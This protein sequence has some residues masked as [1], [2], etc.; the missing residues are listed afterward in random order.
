MSEPKNRKF[1]FDK[2]NKVE[3]GLYAR[4]EA[5]PKQTIDQEIPAANPDAAFPASDWKDEV[6]V[7]LP[8]APLIRHFMN[9]ATMK[10]ILLI[11]GGFFLV[12]VGIAAYVFI[13]GSN[14]ISNNNVVITVNGPTT[15][16][17]GEPLSFDISVRN[18]N[19][20]AL[21]GVKL[22]VDYPESTRTADAQQ[23]SLSRDLDESINTIAHGETIMRTKQAVLFGEADS[24]QH[25]IISVEY[26]VQGS[27]ATYYKEQYYDLL[28]STAPVR[29]VINAVSEAVSGNEIEFSAEITSN[30]TSIISGLMLKV[31]YPFGFSFSSAA[32]SPGYGDNVFLLGDLAPADR[33]IIRIRGT[34]TGQE[35]EDRLFRFNLGIPDKQDSH[36]IGTVFLS[37][38]Q[39]IAIKRPF[40][41]AALRLDGSD[42]ETYAVSPGK[43]IRGE[44]AWANNLDNRIADL[45][46]KVTLSGDS[47]DRVSVGANNG[48]YYRSL[49]NTI[50]WDKTTSPEYAV[51]EPGEN[52]IATFNFSSLSLSSLMYSG[53]T[54]NEISVVVTVNARRLSGTNIPDQIITGATRKVRVSSG[55]GLTARS[56]YFT[57]PFSNQGPVPPQADRSTTYTVVWSLTNSL[58]DASGIRVT[59]ALPTYATWLGNV[60]G[61]ENVTYDSSS[62]KVV[63]DVGDLSAGTGFAGSP[64]EA[65]FQIS[66][67]PS[68]GQLG[69]TPVIVTESVASGVDRFSSAPLKATAK[70]VTTEIEDAPAS[71]KDAG[72]VTQ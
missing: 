66:V 56:M 29:M 15:I 14:Q 18:N 36:L 17:A 48:G 47:L 5:Q 35:G 6:P 50:L 32:P 42:A 9:P 57:G 8:D 11:T 20:V 53:I 21:E 67:V 34:L 22:L 63:W 16:G 45:E 70:S 64:R 61:G 62:R 71:M 31:D 37:S 51:I 69:K 1:S 72:N 68:L 44:I 13:S 65:L 33:R 52:G 7:H 43:S 12:S 2:L 4:E 25:L 55:I 28:I 39:P 58:N 59:A 27:S 38:Q 49:D 40:V 26:R 23:T 10:K 60:N 46:I 3:K 30:S 19:K 24:T 54:G 41:S